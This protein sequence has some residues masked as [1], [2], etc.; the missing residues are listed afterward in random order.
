MNARTLS[1]LALAAAAACSGARWKE[2]DA[3]LAAATE[4]QRRAGFEPK[5][6]PFNT[7]GSFRDT[8]ASSWSIALDSNTT[9][10]VGAACTA[11]CRDLGATVIPPDGQPDS[12]AAAATVVR[13][14]TRAAGSY[15]V[16]LR[17]RC[18]A[19]ERCWW[20]AQVY[21]RGASGHL[22]PAYDPGKGRK[23]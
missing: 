5:S 8:L 17:G 23:T 21:E 18:A 2:A 12:A 3:R 6:G 7:F 14:T 4:A 22:V 19:G 16:R 13:F 11:Q 10:V 20:I 1:I 9:Y 15:A